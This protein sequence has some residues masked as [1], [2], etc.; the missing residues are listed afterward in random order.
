MQEINFKKEFEEKLGIKKGLFV[1]N[2][3]AQKRTDRDL[4]NR[5]NNETNFEVFVTNAFLWIDTKEG[6]K[7]WRKISKR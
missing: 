5:L 6:V 7:F 1:K 2:L 3:I 4:L